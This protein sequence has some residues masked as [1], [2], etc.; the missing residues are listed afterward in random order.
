MGDV[1]GEG[2]EVGGGVGWGGVWSFDL[3]V[4]TQHLLKDNTS[5]LCPVYPA[6]W[7][8]PRSWVTTIHGSLA[9]TTV[10]CSTKQRGR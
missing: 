9:T 10:C 3:S 7:Q 8:P 6:A 4:F 1:G 5:A 2:F